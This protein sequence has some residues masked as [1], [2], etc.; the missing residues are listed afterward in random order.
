VPEE[1]RVALI[2]ERGELRDQLA[3]GIREP[4]LLITLVAG[5]RLAGHE[6]PGAEPLDQLRDP[7]ACHAQ[8]NGEGAGRDGVAFVELAQ[9]HPLGDGYPALGQ[10]GRKRLGDVIGDEAKP[11][12]EVGVE[13]ARALLGRGGH[14]SGFT[15]V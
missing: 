9:D 2:R 7:A 8:R 11:V 12:S 13:R 3:P 5:P 14:R 1:F 6:R 10:L 4:Q 15:S